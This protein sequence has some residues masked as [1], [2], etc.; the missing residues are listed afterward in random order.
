MLVLE[1]IVFFPP[2]LDFSHLVPGMV[3][4]LRGTLNVQKY[5]RCLYVFE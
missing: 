2:K 5:Y 1:L 3:R 4:C